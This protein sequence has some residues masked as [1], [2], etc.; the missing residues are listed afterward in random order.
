MTY[1][2]RDLQSIV[3]LYFKE[4]VIFEYELNRDRATRHNCLNAFLNHYQHGI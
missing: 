4:Q 1:E 2:K 3:A